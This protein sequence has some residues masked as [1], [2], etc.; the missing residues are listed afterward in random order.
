[1]KNVNHSTPVIMLGFINIIGFLLL[2]FYRT[3]L[4]IHLLYIGGAVLLINTVTYIILHHNTF[5]DLYLYIIAAMLVTLGFIIISR[6]D[7]TLGIKQIY[8]YI[9]SIFI[10]YATYFLYNKIKFLKSLKWF[11][12][13]LSAFLFLITLIFG[14]SKGGA[15]NWISIGAFSFQPAEFIKILYVFFLACYFS[16]DKKGKIKNIPE[17]YVV[18]IAAYCLMGFLILQREWGITL[19]FFAVFI[20]LSYVYEHNYL[21]LI[22][23]VLLASVAGILGAMNLYHIQVRISTWLDPWSDIAN[24]GYQITQSLFAIASGGFF[25]TGIGLGNP[26]LIPEVYSDFIFSAIC[27]EMGLFGGF[28]VILLYLI[29]VYR[30]IKIALSLPEGFDKCIVVGLT[31]MFAIQTFIIIGGVIKLVPLTGITLPFISYGGSSLISSFISLGI[32][33]AISTKEERE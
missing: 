7:Y 10:F 11:Y 32:M 5:G 15:K 21:I 23:N 6:I 27:E 28:A 33:Q 25:G 22:C 14:V 30:G 26:D 19:L 13:Y 29:F 16:G 18:N 2:F 3:P 24:K 4:D 20:I 9:I 8:L 1:M 17:K 31:S 12:F